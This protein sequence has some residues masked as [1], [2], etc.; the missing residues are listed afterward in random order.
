MLPTF[1]GQVNVGAVRLFVRQLGAPGRELVVLHGGPD[2]D[3][4][5]LLD[6]L[7]PLSAQARLTFYDHRGCG[8]STRLGTVEG[9]TLDDAV[10]DLAALL[11][12]LN[13]QR[14]TLLGFS[15]GGRVALRFVARFPQLAGA[16]IFAS[17]TA[18]TDFQPALDAKPGYAERKAAAQRVFQESLRGDEP[19]AD[20]T[21][22]LAYAQLPLG[23]WAPEKLAEGRRALAHIR[24]SGEWWQA[25]QAGKLAGVSHPDYAATL[26]DCGLPT[27]ILHGRHDLSFPVEVA[28]RLHGEVP[29]SQLAVLE[30]AHFCFV[31]EPEAWRRAVGDFLTTTA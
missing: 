13:L 26:R 14:P 1:A 8:R 19:P 30:G 27:L 24:W 6:A 3:H 7:Q 28:Q 12:R 17:T 22:A 9:Y 16:L 18:Y 4:S 29:Q 10:D 15:W 5:Y 11:T 31:D 25:L 21:R 23:V 20:I 2:W